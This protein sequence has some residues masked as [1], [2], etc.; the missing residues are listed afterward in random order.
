MTLRNVLALC[1][2]RERPLVVELLK[3]ITEAPTRA[4]AMEAIRQATA[5][6][7]KRALK[8]ARLLKEHGEE[9][10]AVY[11]CR[12]RTASRCERPTCWSVRTRS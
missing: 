6:F 1:G 8:V 5:E 3:T 2:V 7:D 10:L 9:I 11:A 4:A 12:R